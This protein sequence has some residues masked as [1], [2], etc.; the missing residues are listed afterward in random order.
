MVRKSLG[1]LG[2]FS[3]LLCV[4]GRAPAQQQ[5]PPHIA[6]QLDYVLGPRADKICPDRAILRGALR[7]DFGY[8]L[9]Q[10]DAPWRLTIAVS[11]GL[12][13]VIHATMELRDPTGNVVWKDHKRAIHDDCRTLISGVALAVWLGIERWVPPTSPKPATEAPKPATEALK[14]AAEALKPATAQPA[15]P[16]KRPAPSPKPASAPKAARP[17]SA[18]SEATQR[19]RFRSGLGAAFAFGAAPAPNVALSGQVGVRTQYV[20]LSLEGRGDLPAM[21]EKESFSTSRIAGSL[22]PCGHVDIFVGCLLGTVGRQVVFNDEESVSGWYGE[23]GVRLGVEVPIIGPVAVRLSG[24]VAA[25]IPSDAI[26]RV[27]GMDERWI[28]PPINA[29]FSG[30]FVADF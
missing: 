6:V 11:P 25:R 27:N 29:A 17:G 30:G 13:H 1:W 9:V 20:S 22:V 5:Q 10:D 28:S 18:S 14:P 15:P 16:K 19:P 2:A 21:E 4:A 26:V 7:A 12:G 24:D 8:D 23:A 3:A